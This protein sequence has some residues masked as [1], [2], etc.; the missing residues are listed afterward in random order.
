MK[1]AWS[2]RQLIFIFQ[3]CL[4]NGIQ[5]EKD[6]PIEECSALKEWHRW[7]EIRKK[8]PPPSAARDLTCRI[9]R[10]QKELYEVGQKNIPLW[11]EISTEHVY[12]Y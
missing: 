11:E 5:V 12:W 1:I 3:E 4:L 7:V 2:S 8:Y 10:E 9:V 6:E